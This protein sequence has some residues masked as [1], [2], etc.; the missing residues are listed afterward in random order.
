MQKDSS[1]SWKWSQIFI[2]CSFAFCTYISI[3]I[4]FGTLP[5]S[6][7]EYYYATSLAILRGEGISDPYRYF[8]PA[9]YPYLLSILFCLLKNNS[10]VIPQMLNALMLCG[11]LWIYMK[12]PFSNHTIGSYTGYLVLVF[13]V[14]YLS[15]VSVLCSEISYAFFFLIGLLSFWW[16]F[17]RIVSE[18]VGGDRSRVFTFVICGLLLGVSQFIRPVTFAYLFIFT[19]VMVL[20]LRHF[21]LLEIKTGWKVLFLTSLKS[22]VLTW[23]TFF[24][25]SMLLYCGAGYGLTYMPFQKGLWNLYVGFNSESRGTYSVRDAELMTKLG[26]GNQWNAKKISEILKGIA[27]ERIKQNWL[28]NVQNMPEK[29]HNLMDPKGIPYWAIEKSKIKNKDRI[30][31]VS[32]YLCWINWGVLI[33]SLWACVIWLAERKISIQEFLAFCALVAAFL[34]LII[35][36]YLFEVQGRYSNHLWMIMFVCFP[37]SVRAL[38]QS[39]IKMII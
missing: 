37:V 2:L 21:K 16:G 39:L 14:N 20:G 19:L 31:K 25:V 35:H 8:Q 1:L 29:I 12:Y 15:M 11:L 23:V 7:F 33:A 34:Y 28:K 4:M 24:A 17:K 32:G 10:I 26:Y 38:R 3:I 30:Y 5:F 27:F 13:N 18:R 36:S 6:D 9:G 22:L